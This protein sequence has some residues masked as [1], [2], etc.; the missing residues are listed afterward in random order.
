MELN[1]KLIIIPWLLIL[2]ESA[3]FLI[4]ILLLL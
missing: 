3:P 4:D 1:W 2:F